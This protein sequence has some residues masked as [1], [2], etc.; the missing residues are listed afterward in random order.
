M[1]VRGVEHG[2]VHEDTQEDDGAGNGHGHADHEAAF[3]VPTE[4]CEDE[5]CGERCEEA[6]S[7]GAGD[8][9]AF[10]GEKILKMEVHPHAE[11]KK[12]DSD[13]GELLSECH[14]AG[15]PRGVRADD[16]AGEEVA[17]DRRELELLR[18]EA[19]NPGGGKA[20]G[21]G[22]QEREVSDGGREG[23]VRCRKGH[24]SSLG[25]SGGTE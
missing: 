13:L 5:Y 12:D 17:H 19:E 4:Q 10:D 9:H 25:R 21:D 6:L 16:N 1:T 15:E 14:I 22:R 20:R 3:H 11:H 24:H 2:A 18:K 7:D 23:E 8:G